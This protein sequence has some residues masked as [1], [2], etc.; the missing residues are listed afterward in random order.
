MLCPGRWFLPCRWKA[1]AARLARDMEPGCGRPSLMMGGSH[2][3]D[4]VVRLGPPSFGRRSVLW[5]WRPGA[6]VGE[7]ELLPLMSNNVGD[8]LRFPAAPAAFQ[9]RARR[10][11]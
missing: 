10:S 11:V 9:R 2:R 7:G 4:E 6:D 3:V 1:P 8:M 5:L